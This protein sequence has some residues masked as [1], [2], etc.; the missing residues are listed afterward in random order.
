MVI[1]FLAQ[2]FATSIRSKCLDCLAK[3]ILYFLLKRFEHFK[4]FRFMSHQVD[5]TISAEVISKCNEVL[6]TSSSI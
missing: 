2:I 5:I 1:K 4:L 6:V 3:L